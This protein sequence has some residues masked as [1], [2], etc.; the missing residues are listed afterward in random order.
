[1]DDAKI[2]ELYWQ[3]R[4]DAIAET[5]SKYGTYCRTISYNILRSH[6]DAEECVCDAYRHTWEAIPPERPVRLKSWLA[7]VVR[8]ITLDRYRKNRAEK[9]YAPCD[10]LLSELDDCIPSAK[11]AEQSADV[12]EL[13]AYINRWLAELPPEDRKI[14]LRRYWFGEPVGVIAKSKGLSANAMAQKL[15]RL[16]GA[17]KKHLEKEGVIVS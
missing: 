2:I 13:A 17:L 14:F 16:R 5:D 9:R 8:N 3:R 11:S 15:Y 12:K 4:E 10:V 7:V 1:M 6:E